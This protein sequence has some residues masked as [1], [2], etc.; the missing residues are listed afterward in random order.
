MAKITGTDSNEILEGTRFSDDISGLGGDD[1]IIATQGN[2]TIN[3]GDEN[4]AENDTVDYGSLDTPITLERAGRIDKGIEGTDQ[5]IEVET[6]IGNEN[7]VNSIDGST[8]TSGQTSFNARLDREELTVFNI[9]ELG[10]LDFEIENFTNVIGTNNSDTIVG[11]D[12]NNEI[13]GGP[14]D[15]SLRGARGDD[16]LRGR[17]GNDIV[18][19]NKG[20]DSLFGGSDDDLLIGASGNDD[21][22]GNRGNDTLQGDSGVDSLKGASG[23]D[24]FLFETFS[25]EVDIIRD[26]DDGEGDKIVIGFTND[27]NSFSENEATG[28]ILFNGV[29][30]ARVDANQGQ[31][32]FIP[33]DDID[34]V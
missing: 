23:A 22:S 20:N 25:S 26:F 14:G 34:F 24:D 5:I 4:D 13:I 1:L 15:D 21:L 16:L 6:I 17:T 11:N 10:D 9:P 3:G 12:D 8:G 27:I 7:Q 32:F 33:Q 29:A 31:D 28:E 2:D 30:F 19:G 18:K